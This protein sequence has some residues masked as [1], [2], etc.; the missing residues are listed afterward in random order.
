MYDITKRCAVRQKACPC[1]EGA[2]PI[3]PSSYFHVSTRA[4]ASSMTAS[5]I[6]PDIT[7]SKTAAYCTRYS[8]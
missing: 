5:G 8:L 4:A 1:E 2:Q 3:S 7:A 6:L